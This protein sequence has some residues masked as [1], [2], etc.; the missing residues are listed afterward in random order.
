MTLSEQV[1]NQKRFEKDLSEEAIKERRYLWMARTFAL[2]LVVSSI[3]T[4]MLIS[5]LVSL[6]PIVRV[7]PFLLTTLN[8]N[9]QVI[10]VVKPNFKQISIPILTESFIRQYLLSYFSIGSNVNELERRWGIDGD[11]N[12]M[13]ENTVFSKFTSSYADTWIKQAKEEGLTRSVKILVVA[14]YRTSQNENVWQAEIELTE[15]NH[16]SSE[17][18]KI[19]LQILIN[20]AFKPVRQ[21]LTWEERLKNPLGFTVRQFTIKR[22]DS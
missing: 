20:V 2:V 4:I 18:K 17:P 12:W 3:T 10:D 5:A 1:S 8:K 7:Q 19:R 11:I 21:G 15:M 6:T 14:P 16:I 13:S 22:T 9:E